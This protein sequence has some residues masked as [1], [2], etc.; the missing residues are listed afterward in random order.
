MRYRTDDDLHFLSQCTAHDLHPLFRYLTKDREWGTRLMEALASSESYKEYFP[1]HE[2]Y[3]RLLAAELQMLGADSIAASSRDGEGVLYREALADIC[4]KM[5]VH[6]D[7]GWPVDVAEQHLLMKLLVD[8][9]ELMV[10]AEKRVLRAGLE[11]D[12]A[13]LSGPAIAAALQAAVQ[14]GGFVTYRLAV[15]VANAVG[16]TLLGRGLAFLEK[17][18]LTRAIAIAVEPVGAIVTDLWTLPSLAEPAYQ[19]TIPTV[20]HTSYL[21]A[22]LS[23]GVTSPY[24]YENLSDV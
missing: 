2:Y 14:A 8:S 5:K 12:T 17:A 21:R 19:V 7:P 24:R 6:H 13:D 18:T 16:K 3:W 20:V 22:R 1:S 4:D 10:D 11:L 9:L 15:I 23:Q